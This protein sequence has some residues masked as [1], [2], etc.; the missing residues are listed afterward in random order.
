MIVQHN[1]DINLLHFYQIT[2]QL[3][4]SL[5]WSCFRALY[6]L[7]SITFSHL[8]STI[9][10]SPIVKSKVIYFIIPDLLEGLLDC[11]RINCRVDSIAFESGRRSDLFDTLLTIAASEVTGSE[12][13]AVAAAVVLAFK[14]LTNLLNRNEL[15]VALFI[16]PGNGSN[17]GGLGRVPGDDSITGGL[18]RVLRILTRSRNTTQC[19]FAARLLHMLTGRRYTMTVTIVP[20][21]YT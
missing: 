9:Y 15:A 19:Y 12:T 6:I 2:T 5:I 4:F 13:E 14:C 21:Q 18:E 11:L 17:T 8:A 20:S 10:F 1:M 3:I 7:L 16:T